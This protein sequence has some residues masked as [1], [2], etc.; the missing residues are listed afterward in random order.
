MMVVAVS[1]PQRD[2]AKARC[3][4]AWVS[5]C[6][7][8]LYFDTTLATI[9]AMTGDS[10]WANMNTRQ[11]HCEGGERFNDVAFFLGK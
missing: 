2:A 1:A 10:L 5:T 3:V 6:L 11:P 7:P 4:C 8:V 9:L